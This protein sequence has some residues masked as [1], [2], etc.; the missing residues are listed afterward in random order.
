MAQKSSRA[1]WMITS[2]GTSTPNTA[3]TARKVQ[4]A[5]AM[6]EVAGHLVR[7]VRRTAARGSLIGTAIPLRRNLQA[8]IVPG[9]S[10]DASALLGRRKRSH[11]GM[12]RDRDAHHAYASDAL[13]AATVLLYGS[14]SF[15][16][17]YSMADC[18]W[19]DLAYLLSLP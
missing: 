10:G 19:L 4:D 11:A 3:S 16:S 7:S 13:R 17:S 8:E 2:S 15:L 5:R 18:R 6:T 9:H 14:A 1:K 12:R